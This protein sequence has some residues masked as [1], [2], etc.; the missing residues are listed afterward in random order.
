MSE[1]IIVGAIS[2]GLAIAAVVI[3]IIA[4]YKKG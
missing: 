2:A 3:G 4:A 1:A